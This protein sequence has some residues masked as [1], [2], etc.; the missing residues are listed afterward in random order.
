MAFKCVKPTDKQY[1]TQNR[2]SECGG[3]VINAQSDFISIAKRWLEID[4]TLAHQ[5]LLQTWIDTDNQEKLREHFGARLQFGTAGL[6]GHM[7]PGPLG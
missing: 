4:N 6:R 7:E 3:T 1:G 5:Q 2:G